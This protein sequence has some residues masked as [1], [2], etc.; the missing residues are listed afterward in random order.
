MEVF[1][2]VVSCVLTFVSNVAVAENLFKSHL[3]LF[4]GF[5]MT[6]TAVNY[7]FPLCVIYLYLSISIYLV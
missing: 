4:F 7:F 3:F 2:R 1:P 5:S 6:H